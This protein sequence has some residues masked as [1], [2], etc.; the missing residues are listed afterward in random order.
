M[1]VQITTR[2]KLL[3]FIS[4]GALRVALCAS[5]VLVAAAPCIAQQSAALADYPVKSIRIIVASSPGTASDFFARLLGED[6]G[7]FYGKR[8]IVENRPGAGGLIGN[9]QVS[10]A[11]ADGYTLGMVDV[12][13]IITELMRDQPPYR[14]LAD[15][16]GVT[17]VASITNVLAVAPSILARTAP[18]FVAYVRARAGELN[19]ASLG[20]GSASHLAGE[21]FNRALGINAM[22]VPYRNLSDSFIEIALGRVHYA[23]YTLPA[24]LGPVRDG[25]IR[26]LAVMTPQR[27]PALPAV[28]SIA[29]A[30]LPEAQVDTWS[31]IVAPKGTPRRIVEQLHGDIV[32]GLRKAALRELFERQGA[33]STPE[34]TPEGFT[35]LMRGEY[36]RYQALIREG[37]IKPE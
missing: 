33:E 5:A 11:N 21:I 2:Q 35:R 32:R 30:G 16:V 3:R 22:H 19:Y 27:S 36:L 25:R 10:K 37:G 26:A 1:T 4:T 23:I 13:R 14:A 24:V 20:I 8:V 6:L 17:H 15:I 18:E 28:P 7:A 29:E 12:T 31:G 9:T 34:S